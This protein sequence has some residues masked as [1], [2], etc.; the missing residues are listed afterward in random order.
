MK[1]KPPRAIVLLG[2]Q[3]FDPT[4]GAA[5]QELGLEGP[6]AT[7]TAGWQEREGEDAD[8]HEHLAK[9]T[10]NLRLHRRAEEVFK[11][12]A[13]L[14]A[15]HRK[16]QEILR[17]KQDFYRIR[18][19]HELAANHVIRQRKASPEVIEEEQAASIAAIRTLDEYHLGQ[20]R[21]VEAEFDASVRPF[22]RELVAR[23]REEIAKVLGGCAALGIAGGHVAT[24]LNRLRLFGI[25]DLLSGHAVLAWSA[26][27]MA[28]SE[29][30]VLFHDSP[31]QGP[32]AS[33]VLDEGLA[34]IPGVV[35]L[36]QPETRLRMNDPERVS[37][38]ARRFAPARC[39]ALPARA[40]ITWRDGAFESPSSV[41]RLFCDGS[42]QPVSPTDDL[43][44]ESPPR[45]P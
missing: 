16:K 18:L 1:A 27:A 37:V 40:R 8:L 28:I 25:S 32:G 5:V 44:P 41:I 38:M 13:E 35:P 19:E 31:P 14:H 21:R 26:G 6:I 15:A 2:A 17:Q 7:I 20:C 3:R 11:R 42:R 36:P 33:E 39:L 24:L 29:R 43:A 12:D 22:E 4:L 23:H 30:I 10:V 34:L 9:R 45:A